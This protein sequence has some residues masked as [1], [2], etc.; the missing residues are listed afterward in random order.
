MAHIVADRVKETTTT[1]GTGAITLAG[2]VS[3]FQAFSAV[4][5]VA[6]TVP[7]TI[8]GQT[9]TEWET[10]IGTYSG[11]NTLTR[12]TVLS[13]SNAGS[14]VNFSAGTKDVF[15]GPLA[16]RLDPTVAVSSTN[17]A[18]PIP[19]VASATAGAQPVYVNSGFTY[20][21]STGA[22]AV[23]P[24]TATGGT[25]TASTPTLNAT[26]TWNS[27][28]T[29]FNGLFLNVTDTASASTSLLA[30]LQINGSSVF[31]V[32]KSGN[33]ITKNG[34]LLD[35][36][37]FVSSGSAASGDVIFGT[38]L[39]NGTQK[40]LCGFTG[41]SVKNDAYY[42]WCSG[43]DA[44]NSPDLYLYRDAAGTLAQYNGT[45]AQKWRLYNT[46]T[47]STNYERFGIEWSSNVCYAKNA[48]AGTGSARLF[49]PVTGSTTVA[50]LPSASTAGA[51]AR[52][53]VTDAT[54]TTY[55]STVAGGGAN[56]VPVVSDG[57]NWLIG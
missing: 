42:R 9:G 24:I 1:T 4:C 30:N 40:F 7:Y 44:L 11:A 50:S 2:A 25:V 8:A 10:G 6:D 29:T 18:F 56:K 53:F 19:F 43:N 37:I 47:N 28:G 55:L 48:N 38:R 27:A 23:G 33:V 3:G 17:T 51:G 45:N 35:G 34:T 21:P 31:Y 26:Q 41:V 36:C 5:S 13:S 32:D 54:A 46:Y 49:I 12:T 52:C 57:T 39:S 15:C 16:K 20:N 22:L 14:A